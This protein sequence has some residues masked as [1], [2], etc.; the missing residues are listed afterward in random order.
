MLFLED[1]IFSSFTSHPRWPKCSL[2]KLLFLEV[3]F[4][5][6]LFLAIS[7]FTFLATHFSTLPFNKKGI[8]SNP[9]PVS[10]ELKLAL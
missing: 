3:L 10:M 1:S 4:L 9:D 5:A 6:V 2:A 8:I 7:K